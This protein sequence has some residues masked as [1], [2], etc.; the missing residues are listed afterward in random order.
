MLAGGGSVGPEFLDP[1]VVHAHT[2]VNRR[3]RVRLVDDQ[4]RAVHHQIAN[5]IIQFGQ[6]DGPGIA[7]LAFITKNAESGAGLHQHAALSTGVVDQVI[8]AIPKEYE[9]A[10]PQPAQEILDLF[11]FLASVLELPTVFREFC[12]YR[13]HRVDHGTEIVGHPHHVL[14]TAAQL[15]LDIVEPFRIIDSSYFAVYERLLRRAVSRRPHRSHMSVLVAV[16]LEERIHDLRDQ[17]LLRVQELADRVNDERALA[18]VGSHR[19]DR[20]TVAI[21]VGVGI[22]HDD[23]NTV[24]PRLSE[25]A[26]CPHN[27]VRQIEGTALLQQL[28]RGSG[29]EDLGEVDRQVGL[30]AA[31]DLLDLLA[32]GTDSGGILSE[33]AISRFRRIA[34][35][36][37]GVRL[38]TTLR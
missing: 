13:V 6:R 26:V 8:C 35:E 28:L 2:A 32:D 31:D 34:H 16:D 3:L 10:I 24:R 5:A 22:R 33:S 37:G 1:D 36:E 9:P 4:D 25:E 27:H 18:D 14:E 11:D 23:V 29:E 17:E 19:R 20:S 7:R 21:A 15:P 30:G 12:H 38:G